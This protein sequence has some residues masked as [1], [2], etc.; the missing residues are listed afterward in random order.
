[1]TDMSAQRPNNHKNNDNQQTQHTKQ[2]HSN[3]RNKSAEATS[4]S[5]SSNEVITTTSPNSVKSEPCDLNFNS[6]YANCTS[7][8]IKKSNKL[9]LANINNSQQQQHGNHATAADGVGS[10]TQISPTSFYRARLLNHTSNRFF[11]S[12]INEQQLIAL[13]TVFKQ[14]Q[15]L[16]QFEK[17][18]LSN[19][20]NITPLHVCLLSSFLLLFRSKTVI[21]DQFKV[22]GWF[23]NRRYR[24][25]KT[26]Q[27]IH[28]Q[29]NMISQDDLKHEDECDDDLS[30]NEFIDDM[31]VNEADD[32]DDVDQENTLNSDSN[33]PDSA[34]GKTMHK[35]NY[36]QPKHSPKSSVNASPTS[37]PT[38]I[39]QTKQIDS[40]SLLAA[41]ALA[42]VTTNVPVLTNRTSFDH[43]LNTIKFPK[44][45]NDELERVFGKQKYISNTQRDYFAEKF[46]V[47]STQITYWFQNKRRK[48]KRLEREQKD[49]KLDF[50]CSMIV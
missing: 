6:T 25:K 39:S 1:M 36:H 15:Y 9:L 30:Q 17:E 42:V 45:F 38:K 41:A 11:K 37:S 16:N 7:N 3:E 2:Q 27:Q 5:T 35:Y 48:L 46:Q 19:L 8:N 31:D 20:L 28:N 10:A 50:G 14:K 47:E 26:E 32:A 18:Q 4:T 24:Q 22:K 43:Q 34:I 33:E 49:S 44:T 29:E 23:K 12:K 40:F 21:S 13:E